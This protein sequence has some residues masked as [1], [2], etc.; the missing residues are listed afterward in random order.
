[1]SIFR[2]DFLLYGEI[3]IW[4]D[5]LLVS[6]VFALLLMYVDSVDLVASELIALW[7]LWMSL[8]S[9]FLMDFQEYNIFEKTFTLVRVGI[10]FQ[11]WEKEARE[12]R[13]DTQ[14]HKF[15]SL[16]EQDNRGQTRALISVMDC[17][18]PRSY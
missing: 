10:E 6:R 8:S 14:L 15:I 5:S 11:S 13:E 4:S 3:M 16:R 9:I 7:H 1:M 2:L 17:L 12:K 18:S